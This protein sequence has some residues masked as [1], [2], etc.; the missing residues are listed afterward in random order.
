LCAFV[1]SPRVAGAFSCPFTKIDCLFFFVDPNLLRIVRIASTFF[2]EST[3]PLF[4]SSVGP[5]QPLLIL[6]IERL[7]SCPL[8]LSFLFG[9]GGAFLQDCRRRG[10]LLPIFLRLFSLPHCSPHPSCPLP[11]EVSFHFRFTSAITNH[12]FSFES[13]PQVEHTP[14][15]RTCFRNVYLLSP[16]ARSERAC[17]RSV[18]ILLGHDFVV[19]PTIA[20][21]SPP[22]PFLPLSFPLPP[23]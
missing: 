4:P 8:C 19:F 22:Q 3:L 11:F 2:S 15:A 23:F 16:L 7:F 6:P 12:D 5:C 14:M 13:P 20:S 18:P 10:D 1:A 17:R 21:S 9:D